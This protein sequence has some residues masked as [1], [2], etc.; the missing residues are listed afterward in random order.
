MA[1]YQVDKVDF[2]SLLD[3]LMKLYR[4]QTDYYRVFS[5]Y[6]RNLAQLEAEAGL[7]ASTLQPAEKD[8]K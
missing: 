3:S 2:L 1:A 6:H 5:D 4:Y 8:Q 7:L